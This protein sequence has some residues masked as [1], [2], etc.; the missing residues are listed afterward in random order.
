[1]TRAVDAVG[2][3]EFDGTRHRFRYLRRAS[4]VSGFRPFI[5]FARLDSVYEAEALFP[6][7]AQR[8]MSPRRPD[9]SQYLRSLD[10]DDTASTWEQ[11]AR[12]E[13]RLAGD[14]IH[15]VPEPSVAPDGSTT[16]C[17]LVAGIRHRMPDEGRRD[18]VLG[19]LQPGSRL[20]LRD[21]P[22]NPVNPRAILVLQQDEIDLGWVP[23]ILV[24]YVHQVRK[25]GDFRI[26]VRHINGA[27][28]PVHMRLLAELSGTADPGYRAFSGPG[29]ETY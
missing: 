28:T 4:H 12:T 3:L 13:G 1:M 10:L 14:T 2:L 5:G 19:S 24:E 27:E 22:D 26:H 7:F 16:G 6:L 23:N 15:L 17:F 21:E 25:S 11:I 9:Y 20:F 8:A 29:W 18:A